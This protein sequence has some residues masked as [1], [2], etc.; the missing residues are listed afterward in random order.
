MV[1]C[2]SCTVSFYASAS[3]V[4]HCDKWGFPEVLALESDDQEGYDY[5]GIP[6]NGL[7][8]AVGNQQQVDSENCYPNP[9][10]ESLALDCEMTISSSP[11][12]PSHHQPVIAN[13]TA[14]CQ[15]LWG[16]LI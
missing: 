10:C 2:C 4:R 11:T 7:V 5:N 16:H 1:S 8:K 3:V 9:V 13:F 6:T 12:P 14:K 15:G